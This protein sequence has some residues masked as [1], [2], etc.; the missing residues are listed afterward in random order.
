MSLRSSSIN[1]VPTPISQYLK[2]LVSDLQL[3]QGTFEQVDRLIQKLEQLV[4]T[5]DP[6]SY[7]SDI[8]QSV[9]PGERTFLN[10]MYCWWETQLESQFAQAILSGVASD[11]REYALHDRFQTLVSRELAL[12][13]FQPK[14][15][16]LVVLSNCCQ[17]VIIYRGEGLNELS[18]SVL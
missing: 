4:F 14:K 5:S 16:A 18:R 15:V 8:N 12:L 13:D 17:A 9:A 3:H 2:R 11:E 7:P 1:E 6:L 10:Q